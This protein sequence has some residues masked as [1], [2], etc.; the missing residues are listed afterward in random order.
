LVIIPPPRGE[1][2]PGQRTT[3]R[4]FWSA[5]VIRK[6]LETMVADL[7]ARAVGPEASALGGPA[8]RRRARRRPAVSR[9]AAA[10][11]SPFCNPLLI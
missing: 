7:A 2:R 3:S 9:N 1:V 6:V 8:V 11:G 5:W 4:D 10:T